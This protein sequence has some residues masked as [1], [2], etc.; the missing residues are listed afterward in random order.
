MGPLAPVLDS[1]LKELSSGVKEQRTALENEW[2]HIAGSSFAPHTQAVLWSGGTLCVRADSAVLAY[3]LS[4][5]YSGTL[6]KRTKEALG[7][8]TVKKI[9]FRVGQLTP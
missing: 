3:E 2:P 8:E 9:V 7:E 1:L 4:Q 6:L 5:K